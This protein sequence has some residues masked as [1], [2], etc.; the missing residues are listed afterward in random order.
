MKY[1]IVLTVFMSIVFATPSAF[2]ITWELHTG[3]RCTWTEEWRVFEAANLNTHEKWSGTVERIELVFQLSPLPIVEEHV[4]DEVWVDRITLTG[5]GEQALG[6]PL[7]VPEGAK[8]GE[9]FD[10]AIEYGIG[11]RTSYLWGGDV[12]GDGCPDLAVTM[13]DPILRTAD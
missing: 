1:G 12:D 9:W 5:V 3:E 7:E 13:R 4:P 8:P 6:H 2:A 11:G 10:R